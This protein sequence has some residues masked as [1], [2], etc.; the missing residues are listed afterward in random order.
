MFTTTAI[1]WSAVTVTA[2]AL[3]STRPSV[4]FGSTNCERPGSITRMM[5]SE[6]EPP[7]SWNWAVAVVEPLPRFWMMNGVTKPADPAR[8]PRQKRRVT[9]GRKTLVAPPEKP[10][11]ESA[12]ARAPTPWCSFTTLTTVEPYERTTTEN[13]VLSASDASLFGTYAYEVAGA[14]SIVIRFAQEPSAN[15]YQLTSS[16]AIA[17]PVFCTMN[18]VWKPVGPPRV[19]VM[20]GR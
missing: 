6:P 20:L 5:L 2:Y 8:Q 14:R 17:A 3:P 15:L 10:S 12:S 18:G 1:G 4:L 13:C 16:E 9:F 11:Y 19:L 7:R